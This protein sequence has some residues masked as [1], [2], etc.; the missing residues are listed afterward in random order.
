MYVDADSSP[1]VAAI[2]NILPDELLAKI[3]FLVCDESS[4]PAPPRRAALRQK[5]GARDLNAVCRRWRMICL[6]TLSLMVLDLPFES[7]RSS[8][9]TCRSLICNTQGPVDM[10]INI[11][12]TT[13]RSAYDQENADRLLEVLAAIMPHC[14]RWRSLTIVARATSFMSRA[15]RAL[16]SATSAPKL[17]VFR[18]EAV[19]GSQTIPM[20]P[21]PG[22]LDPVH[23]S[24][25]THLYIT[26]GQLIVSQG[27]NFPHALE[28]EISDR[29]QLPINFEWR[30]ISAILRATPSLRALRLNCIINYTSRDACTLE[31]PSPP[32]GPKQLPSL[33]RQAGTR[34]W[35][36]PRPLQAFPVSCSPCSNCPLWAPGIATH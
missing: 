24:A 27:F 30:D 14:G 5:R 26:G 15:L 31:V 16:E 36:A 19:D 33:F 11:N 28:L 7:S 1:F 18:F 6:S 17:R 10:D 35:P 22:I 3:F 32:I 29:D 4:A 9:S 8:L 23:P 2:I 13:Q 20:L 25:L 21:I 34:D 12:L